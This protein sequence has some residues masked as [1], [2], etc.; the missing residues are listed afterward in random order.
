MERLLRRTSVLDGATTVH[1]LA[2]ARM[3]AQHG[4]CV[5]ARKGKRR[6]MLPML[7]V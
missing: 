5:S 1:I 2:D 6:R 4:R 7:L 3:A